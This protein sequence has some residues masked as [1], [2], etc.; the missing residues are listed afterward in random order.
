M[1]D[2]RGSLTTNGNRR[3]Q[4]RLR[5]LWERVD[6]HDITLLVLRAVLA[7]CAPETSDRV[8]ADIADLLITRM[9]FPDATRRAL[10]KY[11]VAMRA[12]RLRRGELH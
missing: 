3:R 9:D 11:R 5:E 6:A 12:N 8:E 2:R 4:S 10:E 1:A 7:R